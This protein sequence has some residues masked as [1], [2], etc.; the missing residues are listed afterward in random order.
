MSQPISDPV[1]D[2][3]N[4]EEIVFTPAQRVA[5]SRVLHQQPYWPNLALG[6]NRDF[7]TFTELIRCLGVF[8][9]EMSAHARVDQE[10]DAELDRLKALLAGGKALLRELTAPE[11]GA[12]G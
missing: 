2:L 4:P 5:L 6:A 8:A 3:L 9:Q 7:P 12:R 10:S 1:L 11:P